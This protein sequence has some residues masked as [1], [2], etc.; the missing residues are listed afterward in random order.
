[1]TRVK[2]GEWV[3]DYVALNAIQLGYAGSALLVLTFGLF[4][5]RM[6]GKWR[7]AA[8]AAIAL[9]GLLLINFSASRGPPLALIFFCILLYSIANFRLRYF[10]RFVWGSL[11]ILIIISAGIGY[12]IFTES[13]LIGRFEE[14]YYAIV[15]GDDGTS[16]SRL[17]LYSLAWEGFLKAPILG[18]FVELRLASMYPHIFYGSFTCYRSFGIP[19]FCNFSHRCSYNRDL[20]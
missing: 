18:N 8:L 3:G 14:T 6:T 12:S 19:Y 17:N 10:L 20:G 15:D 4:S 5:S 9:P 11:I 1:M 2:G 13:E 16:I 7:W